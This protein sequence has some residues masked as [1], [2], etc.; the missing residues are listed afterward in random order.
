MVFLVRR[1]LT[2]A[3]FE[4]PAHCWPLHQLSTEYIHV[5]DLCGMSSALV[6]RLHQNSPTL[7]WPDLVA[8]I[9]IEPVRTAGS[10]AG[11]KQGNDQFPKVAAIMNTIQYISLHGIAVDSAWW[12]WALQLLGEVRSAYTCKPSDHGRASQRRQH[13]RIHGLDAL[14]YDIDYRLAT[15]FQD[16]LSNVKRLVSLCGWSASVWSA[17]RYPRL[18]QNNSTKSREIMPK[19]SG[20]YTLNSGKQLNHY[21]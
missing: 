6:S 2:P 10:R 20:W 8:A 1:Q 3:C 11:R 17:T 16:R 13:T 18:R 15:L 4:T 5:L 7:K 19:Y 21:C 12:R 9:G 14:R